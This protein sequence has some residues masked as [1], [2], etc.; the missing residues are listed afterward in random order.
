[1]ATNGVS[2]AAVTNGK[3]TINGG[4]AVNG[5]SKSSTDVTNLSSSNSRV[6]TNGEYLA[7]VTD[8]A[9]TSNSRV[10]AFF[11]KENVRIWDPRSKSAA[12]LEPILDFAQLPPFAPAASAEG[13]SDRKE[14]KKK[15]DKHSQGRV[16]VKSSLTDPFAAFKAPTP[17]QSAAWPYVLAGRDVVGVAETGSGKTLA[18]GWPVARG[19]LALASEEDGKD[20]SSDDEKNVVRAVVLS[21][22][23]ELAMQTHAALESL[24]E[25][26]APDSLHT[27]CLFGGASKQTQLA[28]LNRRRPSSTPS[29][30]RKGFSVLVVATPG[31]LLDFLTNGQI[32][33][34]RA[35]FVV[36]D[37]A[38]RMLDTGFEQHI[39]QIVGACPPREKR[40]TLMFTATWPSEVRDLAAT[41]MVDAA[42]VVIGQSA[43]A[44]AVLDENGV[45]VAGA[46]ASD[47][48]Q[49]QANRR[50]EQRVEVCS[51]DPRAKEARLLAILREHQRGGARDRILVFCLYKKEAVRVEQFLRQRG[52]SNMRVV[53]I[54]GD[55]RQDKR[56]Q[57]LDAFK[58]GD[59][60]VLV[61]TDVAARGL[62]IPEVKLVIN[63]TVSV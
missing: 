15:K 50:I 61:A 48:H 57:A 5:E 51:P 36:L 10:A 30:R 59:A 22:T 1:M 13:A 8:V 56:T 18:F 38:D 60:T 35:R 2:S 3:S 32:D 53:S 62:D 19:V 9:S 25:A 20:A 17:I 6:V 31:R 16:A 44:A 33:L 28:L 47:T 63:V 40:Q 54:H 41:F 11:A 21:P 4:V 24:C 26:C 37:E 42:R 43:A 29:G 46:G 7:S 39:R 14:K 23:R 45:E 34:S 27:V 49:L 52:G 55:L 12:T 58:K